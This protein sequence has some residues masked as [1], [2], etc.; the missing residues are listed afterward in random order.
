MELLFIFFVL[1]M[2]FN[3]VAKGL[4]AAAAQKNPPLLPQEESVRD[5]GSPMLDEDT[6][7]TADPDLSPWQEHLYPNE[8]LLQQKPMVT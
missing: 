1:Y 4:K 6:R 5:L 3:A 8:P 2:I 7:P